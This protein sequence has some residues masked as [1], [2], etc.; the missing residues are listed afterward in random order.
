M[1]NEKILLGLLPFWSSLIPPMGISCLKSFL[2]P[3]GFNIKTIDANVQPGF[4]EMYDNY[5]N[6]LK[7][8]VPPD[9]RGNFYNTAVTVLQKHLMAH[10]NHQ[11]EKEYKKLIKIIVSGFFFCHIHE[12]QVSQ[13]TKIIA[14]FYTR[15]ETYVLDLLALEKPTI[16]GLSVYTDTVP[17]S[18]FAFQ[19]TKKYYP[20]T[21]TIMGGGIF[22]EDLAI[23]SP[24]FDFF[25]EKTPYIDKI[26]VGEGELLFLKYLK[27]E[28][29]K[30]QGVYTLEDINSQALDLNA[31]NIPDF[32]DF[33]LNFYPNLAAYTSRSCPFKC[34]FC[35]E[36]F[37][38]GKF[39]KK[40]IPRIVNELTTLYQQHQNQLFL[41]CD[42]LLNPVIS[43]LAEV[44]IQSGFSIYWDGYLRA[45]KPVCDPKNTLHWRRGGFY[46]ARLGLESGS[47]SLLESMGKRI[48]PDQIKEAVTSLAHAGIKTTTYWVIGYPGETEK[49]FQQTLDLIEE[50]KDDIYE[51][52]CNAFS[53]FLT[54]QVN[55]EEWAR[56][57]KSHL[58]YPEEFTDML[59]LQTW[60]LQGE[61]SRE[62]TNQR[63]N[64]FSE[65]CKK[66]GIPN[67]YTLQEIYKADERWKSLHRNAVPSMVDFQQGKK[68]IDE[69]KHIKEVVLG[70]NI[71]PEEADWGF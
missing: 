5:L 1:N 59:L 14:G 21:K 44:F 39:R 64:L 29:P 35:S 2:Q 37:F 62:E 30:N 15:L 7:E 34:S 8:S 69:N 71:H 49:D 53:Y 13:L 46:R 65:H 41:M 18:L 50:L 33:D 24:N 20:H 22:T 52:D 54:G 56:N 19:L 6:T 63:M 36:G 68:Y 51:A 48:M 40:K 25:L 11:N 16:L 3:H 38:W 32:S 12:T 4:R 66:L 43:E 67:P 17:A 60:I 57:N 45:D 42:S 10:L 23:G 61:P 31:A 70:K 47:Q 26:I 9:K 55:S 27:G 58:L 28:L